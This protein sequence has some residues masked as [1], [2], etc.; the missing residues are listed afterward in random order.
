MVIQYSSHPLVRISFKANLQNI[1]DLISWN[2]SSLAVEIPVPLK[3][4]NKLNSA[5]VTQF[6]PSLH[7]LTKMW[8]HISYQS[9]LYFLKDPPPPSLSS[10]G[11]KERCVCNVALSWGGP[12]SVW[13]SLSPCLPSLKHFA[14]CLVTE[15]LGLVST[16]CGRPPLVTEHLLKSPAKTFRAETPKYGLSLPTPGLDQITSSLETSMTV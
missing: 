10:P 7:L 16:R 9:H 6:Y 11:S 15:G 5:A 4:K 14:S 3:K 2:C 1:A 12:S 13:Y 8:I